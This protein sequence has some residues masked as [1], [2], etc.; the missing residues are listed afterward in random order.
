MEYSFDTPPCFSCGECQFR[1]KL[2]LHTNI[3]T[4]KYH[5]IIETNHTGS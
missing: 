3:F 4:T 1:S 2:T 5:T